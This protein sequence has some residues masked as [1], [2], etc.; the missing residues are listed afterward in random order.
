MPEESHAPNGYLELWCALGDPGAAARAYCCYGRRTRSVELLC[1]P[2]VMAVVRARWS[3]CA[4][5][6]LLWPSY[7]LGGAAVRACCG[8]RARP[9]MLELLC[10][11]IVDD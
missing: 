8:R 3:R 4:R 11:P 6:L 9:V 2:I 10:V 7:A 1:A 5:L